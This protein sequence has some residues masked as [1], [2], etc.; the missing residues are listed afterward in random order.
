MGAARLIL[1]G[2]LSR[3]VNMSSE[4]DLVIED[5]RLCGVLLLAFVLLPGVA[6][7]LRPFRYSSAGFKKMPV[8]L[9]MISDVV[10]MR[11]EVVPVT[12]SQRWF[13]I[14]IGFER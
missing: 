12:G 14:K 3:S 7:R 2:L 5:C 8:L 4:L 11:E 6:L 13:S 10:P 1:R 9:W